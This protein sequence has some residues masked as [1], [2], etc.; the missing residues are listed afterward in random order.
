MAVTLTAEERKGKTVHSRRV[1]V[2]SGWSNL[3]SS[4]SEV[5]ALARWS[6]PESLRIYARM[7][8]MYQARKRDGLLHAHIDTSGAAWQPQVDYTEDELEACELFASDFE[9]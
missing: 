4:E 5:Q 1:T 8:H 7:N 2:A 6:T 9:D 3:D